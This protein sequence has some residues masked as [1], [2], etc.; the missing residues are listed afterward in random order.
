MICN[1]KTR[2]L[3]AAL[4]AFAL[5][6]LA[7]GA[8]ANAAIKCSDGYQIV[9][10]SPIAT[11]YCQDNLVAQVAR[12]YGFKASEAAVRNNPNYKRE[13]CRYV[14]RDNRLTTACVNENGSGRR[15]F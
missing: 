14:G 9:N 2:D 11:P 6:A 3:G 13:L 10:G 1:L 4:L 7:N 8:P 15:P 12:Q 5:L